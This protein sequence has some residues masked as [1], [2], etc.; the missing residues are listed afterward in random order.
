MT[1]MRLKDLERRKYTGEAELYLL[2][3]VPVPVGM[4]KLESGRV[5]DAKLLS[6]G[7]VLTGV[8]AL[9]ILRR[10][11]TFLTVVPQEE[12]SEVEGGPLSSQEI[13]RT[14]E[15]QVE[16]KPLG[17]STTKKRPRGILDMALDSSALDEYM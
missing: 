4:L 14:E 17:L 5:V 9:D 1:A 15:V 11:D 2:L 7:R 10:A 6:G 8:E 13:H 3:G 16:R 12:D